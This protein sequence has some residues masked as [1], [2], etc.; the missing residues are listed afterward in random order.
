MFLIYKL[1]ILDEQKLLWIAILLISAS[2]LSWN[3][4]YNWKILRCQFICSNSLILYL[5]HA[6]FM[7][8]LRCLSCRLNFV[9]VRVHF[10]G[11]RIQPILFRSDYKWKINIKMINIVIQ[12]NAWMMTFKLLNNKQHNFHKQNRQQV[13]NEL[14]DEFQI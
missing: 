10:T 11:I 2:V 8:N 9:C 5:C 4:R 6:A 13:D 1:L 3:D 12:K 14:L 7:L